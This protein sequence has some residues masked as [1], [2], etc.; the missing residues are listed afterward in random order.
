MVFDDLTTKFGTSKE[1]L[2][3]LEWA[4][5]IAFLLDEVI[6]N[7][8]RVANVSKCLRILEDACEERESIQG[9]SLERILET[10]FAIRRAAFWDAVE[11]RRVDAHRWPRQLYDIKLHRIFR[12]T[13]ADAE[14]LER[15]AQDYP[16]VGG[17]I[18]AF[19]V[20]AD[21]LRAWG[22]EDNDGWRRIE[23][24]AES[25]PDFQQ[26]VKRWKRSQ[27]PA[28]ELRLGRWH[29]ENRLHAQ[30]AVKKHE[31][32]LQQ[33][34]QR[35]PDIRA[36]IAL[37]ALWYLHNVGRQ[38]T[39]GWSAKAVADRYGYDLAMAAKVGFR[40]LWRRETPPLRHEE[41]AN[42]V[43]SICIMGLLGLDIDMLEG[44]NVRDL[45]E[46]H[47]RKAIAYAT[48]TANRLPGWLDA[49]AE[50]NH[51]ILREIFEPTLRLDY[52]EVQNPMGRL[53]WKLANASK[54]IRAAC[55]SILIDLLRAGDPQSDEIL[56]Y[57]L[58]VM[59][60][61]SDIDPALRQLCQAS[62]VSP[63]NLYASNRL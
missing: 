58:K 9:I 43:P 34:Q 8:G 49:C 33:L 56:A 38:G 60:G 37:P 11:R 27:I 2:R 20:L 5:L 59:N 42:I 61:L 26:R 29:L 16:V 48:W 51:S 57:T 17:R 21:V 14:W 40:C 54:S 45:D 46:Q 47:L 4:P 24:I 52:C 10:S 36:W 32:T 62:V 1:R 3:H 23:R 12:L 22:Q 30:N 44:L 6:R 41:E 18:L 39:D 19:R 28:P 55:A 13:P 35:M 7:G 50:H 25:R 31:N 63:G 15:D 53:L